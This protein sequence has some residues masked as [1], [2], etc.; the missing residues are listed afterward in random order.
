MRHAFLTE[1]P[2]G[3]LKRVNYFMQLSGRKPNQGPYWASLHSLHQPCEWFNYVLGKF[4][5]FYDAP[6]SQCEPS[7]RFLIR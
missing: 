1:S 2:A 3:W 5:P 6:I 4:W 7:F